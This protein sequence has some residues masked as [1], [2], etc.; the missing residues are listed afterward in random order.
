MKGPLKAKSPL[1]GKA[2][3]IKANSDEEVYRRWNEISRLQYEEWRVM[4]HCSFLFFEYNMGGI[5]NVG[6]H[7][8]LARNVG[9]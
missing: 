5:R 4:F 7:Q 8:D 6:Y 9:Y 3:L 1:K 2:P